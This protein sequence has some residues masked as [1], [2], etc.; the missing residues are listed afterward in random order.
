MAKVLITTNPEAKLYVNVDLNDS[1]WSSLLPENLTSFK[2]EELRRYCDVYKD[3]IFPGSSIYNER[4]QITKILRFPNYVEFSKIV[5]DEVVPMDGELFL[6]S[7]YF[8]RRVDGWGSADLKKKEGEVIGYCVNGDIYS[9]KDEPLANN[10]FYN[11]VYRS[12]VSRN[13]AVEKLRQIIDGG[14]T[15]VL[16]GSNKQVLESLSDLVLE[17]E[18]S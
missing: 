5:A 12:L 11:F 6:T 17:T 7:K 18:M 9:V 10:I 8:A 1:E 15:L 14:V 16:T 3:G 13:P 2:M 4:N